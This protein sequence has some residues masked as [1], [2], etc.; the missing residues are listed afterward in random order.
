MLRSW[1]RFR[2]VVRNAQRS[3]CNDSVSTFDRFVDKDFETP[4]IRT[5]VAIRATHAVPAK[6]RKVCPREALS[7]DQNLAGAP[8]PCSQTTHHI[9][10]PSSAGAVVVR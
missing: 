4:R 1:A 5:G 7:G 8:V 2:I 6:A 10:L 3:R 9:S